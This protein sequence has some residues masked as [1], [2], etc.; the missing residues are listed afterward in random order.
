MCFLIDNVNMTG[1][2]HFVVKNS[3]K[4]SYFTGK[5]HTAISYY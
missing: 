2:F 3:T 1:N 4:I 5:I